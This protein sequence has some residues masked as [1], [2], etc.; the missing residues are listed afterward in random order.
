[1]TDDDKADAERRLFLAKAGRFAVVT[2]PAV[3]MLLST[4]GAAQAEPASGYTPTPTP[5]PT[6]TTTTT[7]TMDTT[8]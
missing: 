7:T 3:A 5:T 1:M 6:L 4:T 2:P 8:T